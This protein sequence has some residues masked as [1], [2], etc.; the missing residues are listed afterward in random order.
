MDLPEFGPVV[1]GRFP[2]T[3]YGIKGKRRSRMECEAVII[4]ATSAKKV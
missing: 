1:W 3:I 4:A 2:V